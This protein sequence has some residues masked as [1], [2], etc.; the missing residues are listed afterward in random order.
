MFLLNTLYCQQIPIDVYGQK[1]QTSCGI[2]PDAQTDSK[3]TCFL[4]YLW[5]RVHTRSTYIQAFLLSVWLFYLLQS[6]Q[7]SS[8][9]LFSLPQ[10]VHHYHLSSTTLTWSLLECL[11]V[12]DTVATSSAGIW[13]S[14]RQWYVHTC[15]NQISPTFKKTIHTLGFS[16]ALFE[17]SHWSLCS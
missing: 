7:T 6:H 8:S 10:R 2:S 3:A 9:T 15:M 11:T 17:Q 12:T 1:V 13:H 5:E 4:V 14:Y 16:Q